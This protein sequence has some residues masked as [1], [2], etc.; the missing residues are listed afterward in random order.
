[1]GVALK[2]QAQGVS[3]RKS[4][5][6]DRTE[7]SPEAGEF[8]RKLMVLGGAL[9]TADHLMCR[10]QRSL[11]QSHGGM[12]TQ[13]DRAGPRLRSEKLGSLR[14][15]A[16]ESVHHAMRR[17]HENEI[18][19]RSRSSS[20]KGGA[21]ARSDAHGQALLD[22][23]SEYLPSDVAERLKKGD[24][25]ELSLSSLEAVLEQGDAAGLG[26]ESQEMLNQPLAS[27]G[28]VQTLNGLAKVSSSSE[29]GK[30][31]DLNQALSLS[32]GLRGSELGSLDQALD[33]NSVRARRGMNSPGEES[34]LGQSAFLGQKDVSGL[35]AQVKFSSVSR[36]QFSEDTLTL[37]SHQVMKTLQKGGGEF[38]LRISP[39][40]LGDMTIHVRAQGNEVALKI[41]ATDQRVKEILQESMASLQDQL[42]SHHL[43]LAR[44]DVSVVS[45]SSDDS[46]YLAGQFSQRQDGMNQGWDHGF[47]QQQGSQEQGSRFIRGEEQSRSIRNAQSGSRFIAGSSLGVRSYSQQPGKLDLHA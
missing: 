1:M 38:K 4:H 36:P 43:V 26:D 23:F 3:N 8:D 12:K 37:M 30:S 31:A 22:E 40:Y 5:K 42:S 44:Y 11:N 41:Q 21:S 13:A 34:N 39:E 47:F 19:Q 46:S 45:P 27:N 18:P 14:Q 10:D 24:L 7:D 16:R 33:L 32:Q 20:L 6:A 17:A 9:A 28:F 2:D 35:S 29:K 25:R 15:N